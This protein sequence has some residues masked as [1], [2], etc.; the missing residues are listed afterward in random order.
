[1]GG[2]Q[3]EL[4]GSQCFRP[5]LG[6]DPAGF[7]FPR[8]EQP[9]QA[10]AQYFAS[11]RERGCDQHAEHAVISDIEARLKR[12]PQADNG[13][14]DFGPRLKRAGPDIEQLFDLGHGREHDSQ[15]TV[16]LVRG[17]GRHAVHDFPLQHEMHIGY[18]RPLR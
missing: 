4:R 9:F 10:I 12:W 14:P 16:S 6:I 3:A 1:M 8:R 11:M 17:L 7:N 15:A 13:R 18:C 2:K 5:E